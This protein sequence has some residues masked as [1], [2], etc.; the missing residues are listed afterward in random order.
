MDATTF[1]ALI[2]PKKITRFCSAKFISIFRRNSEDNLSDN[3]L[4]TDAFTL[5]I[6]GNSLIVFRVKQRILDGASC[7]ELFIISIM[8]DAPIVWIKGDIFTKLGSLIH[9]TKM[10]QEQIDLNIQ[11][12]EVG[13][14]IIE[15]LE[16]LL[17]SKTNTQTNS[18]DPFLEGI[19]MSLESQT[20]PE[21][22]DVNYQDIPASGRL[23]NTTEAKLR[24]QRKENDA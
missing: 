9:C 6:T 21:R 5:D 18:N 7:T 13:N 10:Y 11:A 20:I 23:R 12:A 15:L 3:V 19:Y 2:Q 16:A 22:N 24:K 14:K 17:S 8:Q 4:I 1:R